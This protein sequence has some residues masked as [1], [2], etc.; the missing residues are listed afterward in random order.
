MKQLFFS[1]IILC[2]C[3]NTFAQSGSE[4]DGVALILR[5][6]GTVEISGIAE[7]WEKAERGFSLSSNTALR[8]GRQSSCIIRLDDGSILRIEAGS[9]LIVRAA[10]NGEELQQR[11]VQLDFG[12]LSFSVKSIPKETFQFKSPTAV[13]SIKGTDGVFDSEGETS[14]LGILSSS[15]QNDIADFLSTKTNESQ[16]VGIGEIVKIDRTGKL[17]RRLFSSAEKASVA[18]RVET[19]RAEF[20]K[21]AKQ[22]PP[23]INPRNRKPPNKQQGIMKQMRNTVRK[24]KQMQQRP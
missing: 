13:A 7:R 15:R 22:M 19:L 14:S 16:S 4:D 6:I 3:R 20:D 5:T 2:L 1:L 12:K 21:G 17:S 24:Q 8:T 9:K 23:R 11:E 10:R 18:R